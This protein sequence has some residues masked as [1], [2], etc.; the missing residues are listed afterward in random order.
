[1]TSGSPWLSLPPLPIFKALSAHDPQ[2]TA[3]I[4]S[5]SGKRFTYGQLLDD[6]ARGRVKLAR[7]GESKVRG[8]TEGEEQKMVSFLVENGYDYVGAPVNSFYVK[9]YTVLLDGAYTGEVLI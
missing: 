1:M 4:H 5:A 3:I 6:T 7:M 9:L 2:K 8:E